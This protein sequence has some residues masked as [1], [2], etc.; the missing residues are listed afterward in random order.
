M[1]IHMTLKQNC[2]TMKKT[3]DRR[4]DMTIENLECFLLVAE[5]L[6]FA[7]AADALH[8]SQ[9]AVTKQIRSLERELG[10]SLF[11]RT[12]RH[13]ALTPAGESFYKDAKEIVLKTQM[14]VNRVQKQTEEDQ[15]LYIGVSNCAVLFYLQKALARFHI[16]Y[17]E[18]RPDIECLNYKRILNL[19]LDQ[20]LDL[21]F[22][23]R[24]NL[25][26]TYDAAF[27]ELKKDQVY[28]LM[29][30]D[31][32][33]DVPETV[34]LED[35]KRHDLIACSPLDAPLAIAAFQEKILT[36]RAPKTVRY[37]NSVEA[38][39]CL[40]G[41]GMGVALLPGMLCLK[42]E[43]FVIRPVEKSP[44]LSFGVFYRERGKSRYQDAF[45]KE[46]RA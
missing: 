2:G 34:S 17:P 10:T 11:V 26:K 33:M 37:C 40:A 22:Y 46:L 42:S 29:S 43:E 30:R 31:L 13:V 20:K 18:A 9:P 6:N 38:A 27:L 24:E 44:E 39:H 16:R 7:R 35:L 4:N 36:G 14:A 23:Y 28:C 3:K 25:P 1:K 19:F 5:N 32:A 8:I 21:L 41:A 15:P 45:L 12:T